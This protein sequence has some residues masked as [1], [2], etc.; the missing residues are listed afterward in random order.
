V[1]SMET[2]S[3]AEVAPAP[4]K[5]AIGGLFPQAGV[6]PIAIAGALA[7]ATTVECSFSVASW[8][9]A[10]LYGTVL[11]LWWAGVAEVLWRAGKRWPPVLKVSAGN[12]GVQLVAAAIVAVLHLATLQVTAHWIAHVGSDVQRE[13]Y[14]QLS[15]FNLGRFGVEFLTYGLVWFACTALHTQLAAQG[16]AMRSLQLERQ[17]SSAHLRAL[18]MQLE[19]HFLFNA[20]NA[21]AALMDLDRKQEALDTPE[22]LNTILK[23]GLKRTTPS[24]IPLAQELEIVESYL[25]IERV[26][27]A[28][29][30]H[31]DM[32]LDPNALDGLVP[33]FLLQPIIENAVRHGIAQCENDGYIQT[34]VKRVGSHMQLEVRDSGPGMN[35]KSHP[36]FGIGLS[37]TRERLVHFYEDDFELRASQPTSGGFEVL[38]T[39]PYEQKAP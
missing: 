13:V 31:V 20:L 6:I 1:R 19:P 25:A 12:A 23:T 24:K 29:R 15:F 10:L 30:L 37:N 11:W 39:I 27:F 28:D 14:G 18:Q 7:L 26:R 34:S 4:A 21:V 17:L 22:H 32:N 38:I 8:F 33:C 5:T 36:G 2:R 3:P 35:G 9:R 16:D